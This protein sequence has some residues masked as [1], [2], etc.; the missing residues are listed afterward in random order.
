MRS[1]CDL[2]NP[3][4]HY[5]GKRKATGGVDAWLRC[6]WAERVAQ[7]SLKFAHAAA[8]PR[9][10]ALYHDGSQFVMFYRGVTS[11]GTEL[12]EKRIGMG[13]AWPLRAH[14]AAEG[15]HLDD[16]VPQRRQPE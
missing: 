6:A 3:C 1:A 2:R 9:S 7:H 5:T 16:V 4:R 10:P 13:Q 14:G 12:K 8:L 15:R 11:E